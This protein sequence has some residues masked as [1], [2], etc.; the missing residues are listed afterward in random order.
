MPNSGPRDSFAYLYLTL[1]SN[2]YMTILTSRNFNGT[3]L[4]E[5]RNYHIC[6]C[7]SAEPRDSVVCLGIEGLDTPKTATSFCMFFFDV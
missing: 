3:S 1:V 7:H 6:T 4:Q 5:T 2:S